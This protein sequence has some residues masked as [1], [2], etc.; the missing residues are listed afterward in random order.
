MRN[1]FLNSPRKGLNMRNVID[2]YSKS[3]DSNVVRGVTKKDSSTGRDRRA[4]SIDI[5]EQALKASLD[6]ADKNKW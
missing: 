5:R 3:R 6:R 4:S 2:F 1:L